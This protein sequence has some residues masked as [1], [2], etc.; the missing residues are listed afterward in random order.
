MRSACL[1]EAED[2]GLGVGRNGPAQDLVRL[3]GQYPGRPRL[4]PDSSAIGAYSSWVSPDSVGRNRFHRP[5]CLCLLLQLLDN[6]RDDVAIGAA[7]RR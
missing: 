6:R 7:A 1:G 4:Q 5:W 3:R 2:S